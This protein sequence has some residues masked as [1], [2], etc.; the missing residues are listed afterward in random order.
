MVEMGY[1]G[2]GGGGLERPNPDQ[3]VEMGG[4]EP[5]E[6]GLVVIAICGCK[7]VMASKTDCW[8]EAI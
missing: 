4:I 1:C 7:W 2:S 6:S 8:K 5:K 3:V